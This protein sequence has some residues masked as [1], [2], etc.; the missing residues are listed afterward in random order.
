MRNIEL[1]RRT[2]TTA[3]P[4]ELRVGTGGCGA[5][6]EVGWLLLLSLECDLLSQRSHVALEG[7]GSLEKI[8]K[9]LWLL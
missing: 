7:D 6:G 1:F 8:H 3:F 5:G 2:T 4:R 9:D